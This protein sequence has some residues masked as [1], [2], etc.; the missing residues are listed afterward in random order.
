[1]SGKRESRPFPQAAG[2]G[3]TA[4]KGVLWPRVPEQSGP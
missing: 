2:A 1:M 3:V 4:P